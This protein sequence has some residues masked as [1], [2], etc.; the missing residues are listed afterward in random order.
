VKNQQDIF[1]SLLDK[2]KVKLPKALKT[3]VKTLF[4]V[5]S[6]IIVKES[7]NW[8]ASPAEQNQEPATSLFFEG[9]TA[10]SASFARTL[11][12]SWIGCWPI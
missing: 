12:F 9:G 6:G 2:F 3:R 5:M 8:N 7:V 4:I 1:A 10:S 11:N